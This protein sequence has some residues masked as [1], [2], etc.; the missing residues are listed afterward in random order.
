MV[1]QKI[2]KQREEYGRGSIVTEGGGPNILIR[3]NCRDG[4]GTMKRGEKLK[5]SREGDLK[6]EQR[7]G[8]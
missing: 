4:Q 8:K 7:R 1:S 6:K 2:D 3:R 5:K